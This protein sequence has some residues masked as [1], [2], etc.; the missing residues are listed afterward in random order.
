MLIYEFSNCVVQMFIVI[1]L[2]DWMD[3]RSTAHYSTEVMSYEAQ[4][5]G[6]FR[7]DRD[8]YHYEN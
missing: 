5:K 6:L 4:T 2:S 7:Y 1:F 8:N 3:M